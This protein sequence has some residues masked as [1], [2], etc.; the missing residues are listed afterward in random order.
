MPRALR[1]AAAVHHLFNL[2]LAVP[3]WILPMIATVLVSATANA[4]FYSA[5]TLATFVFVGALAL[6]TVLY[7]VAA[8]PLRD[9]RRA[10][11]LSLV[12]SLVWALGS[13]GGCALVGTRALGF[14]GHAYA[15]QGGPILLALAL[16]AFPQVAKLHYVALVRIRGRFRRGIPLVTAGGLLELALAGFGAAHGGVLGLAIGYLVA[17]CAEALVFLPEIVR[18]VTGSRAGGHEAVHPPSA[19]W[20]RP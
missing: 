12:L 3:S 17:N 8:Q 18:A 5:W 2:A 9:V 11:R 4:Y 13:A 10:L 7:A 15:D 6:T 20:Q 14:F 19:S 16:S 1:G